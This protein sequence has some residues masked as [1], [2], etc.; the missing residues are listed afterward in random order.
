MT[1]IANQEARIRQ[2]L[3]DNL[4][5]VFS[6]F[7]PERRMKAIVANYTEDVIWTSPELIARGHEELNEGAQKLLDR[8]PN[9]IFTAA[10]PVHVLRDLGYLAFTYGLP[11]QPPAST[12]YDVAQ[13]RDGRI[14]M[15]YTLLT[16]FTD[17]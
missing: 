13:V 14:A 9:F 16:G 6:E 3:V 15:L 10:G 2:L 4:F 1:A 17:K 8:T 12:G 5:A 11:Q 7:D